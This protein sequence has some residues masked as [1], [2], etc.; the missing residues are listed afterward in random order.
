MDG[1]YILGGKTSSWTFG[2]NDFLLIKIDEAG[3]VLWAKHYGGS[4]LEEMEWESQRYLEETLDG[5]YIFGG[6]TSSLFTF[7]DQ[8]FFAIKTDNQGNVG[9]CTYV[10]NIA[11]CACGQAGCTLC[12]IITAAD[13]NINDPGFGPLEPGVQYYAVSPNV[14]NSA[15]HINS[16][17]PNQSE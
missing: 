13:L 12:H 17:C 3:E 14:Y 15:I 5:G 4:M 11:S 16:I 6:H 1:G 7:D 10:G 9:C 2:S 8:D